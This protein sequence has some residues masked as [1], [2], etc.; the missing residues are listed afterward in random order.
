VT[1]DLR[2]KLERYE[3]KAA[4]CTKAAQEARDHA[5]RAFYEELAHYYDELAADFRRV[6]AKRTGA[7]LAAE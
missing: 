5:G 1:S 4:H 2:T 6:L 7:S 3:S